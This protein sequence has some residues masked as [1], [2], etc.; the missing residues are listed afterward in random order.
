MFVLSRRLLWRA[1]LAGV[2]ILT[3]VVPSMASA[4]APIVG[5]AI[6]ITEPDDRAGPR[7]GVAY[8]TR[9][10]E[11]AR[12][13]NRP[14]SPLTS[15]FGWQVEH[16]FDLGS[17][18]PT[19]MTEVVVMVGGLEQNVFL[20]SATWL[21]GLRQTNGVEFGVGPMLTGSGTQLA[22]AAGI[23]QRFERVNIPVNVAISPARVGAAISVTAGF[24]MRRN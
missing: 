2:L 21:I 13:E 18:M 15:L 16:P 9:G 4:Q 23:T 7:F 12:N 20:P 24:N 5:R 6:V 19:L 22:F 11:T 1:R 14:F 10:S 8:L 3:G 17:D